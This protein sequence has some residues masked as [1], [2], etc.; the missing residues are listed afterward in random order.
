MKVGEHLGMS[1]LCAAALLTVLGQS[2]HI[3]SQSREPQRD[4]FICWEKTLVHFHSKR[5]VSR[6][7]TTLMSV[8]SLI[9]NTGSIFIFTK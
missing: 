8:L 3:L 7:I 5:C 6:I 1:S 4:T 2:F 9:K